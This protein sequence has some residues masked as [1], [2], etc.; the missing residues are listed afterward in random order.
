M[1]QF[2]IICFYFDILNVSILLLLLLIEYLINFI[3]WLGMSII[4][5]Q[6]G[7]KGKIFRCDLHSVSLQ[8]CCSG[9]K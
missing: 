2:I 6:H 5:A 4:G 8:P 1:L 7:K 3:V 9:K